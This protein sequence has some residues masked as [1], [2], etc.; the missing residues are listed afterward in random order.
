MQLDAVSEY[1]LE[2]DEDQESEFEPIPVEPDRRRIFTSSSDPTV[3]GLYEDYKSGY[4]ILQPDFQR[5]FVWDRSKSSRLIE[6]VLLNVPL[7][8]V[9]LAQE[10]DSRSSVIDGQ[11]R[12]TSFFHFIDGEFALQGLKVATELNGKRFQDLDRG[13][14]RIIRNYPIRSIT[15]LKESDPELRFEIF[16]RLNTGSVALNDQ[17]LR[18]CVYRGPYNHLIKELARDLDFMYLL[19]MQEPDKRMRD[20]ELVLRFCAF[21]HATYLNYRPPIRHFLNR[22]MEKYQFIS[23]EDAQDLRKAFK[24][25]VQIIRSVLDRHA[26]KRFYRG[27]ATHP[28]GY[29]EPKKFNT[30]L[31]D[32]LMWG[33]T[34]Y[35]KN[36]VFQHLDSIRES[37]VV[38]MSDDA[39]FIDS[40]EL[41]TSSIRMVQRRFDKWRSA[42]DHVLGAPHREVRCFSYQLKESLYQQNPT[43]AICENRIQHIDDAAVDHIRQYWTGGRT[44]PENARLTHRF[45][46]W[47]RPRMEDGDAPHQD[48]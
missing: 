40:I 32:I 33:F 39:E 44:I 1:E 31:Y 45:C 16:E 15:I 2:F 41:S 30:S 23:P 25:S 38:L 4:L 18:N 3:G 27:T 36:Q 46:N 10:S 24:G 26:F 47:S 12:L 8:V 22:D 6:S 20:V 13:Q 7:P 42:L 35:D 29:W 11:Q 19:G 48:D 21:Y 28:D 17:E 14:Q 43:C 5:Y 37:L 9:Y 34:R